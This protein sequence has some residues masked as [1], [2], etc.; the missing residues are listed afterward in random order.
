MSIST[1]LFACHDLRVHVGDKEIVKGVDLEIR[2]GEKHAL[3]G[4]NGSGKSTLAAALMGHP[5]YRVEG[6]HPARRRRTSR[7]CRPTS[8]RAA[9]CS[10]AS[11]TRW[12]CPA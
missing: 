4:P 7:S 12:R 1:P 8:A 10:S 9:A 2:A 6:T 11:S 5:A 3:M